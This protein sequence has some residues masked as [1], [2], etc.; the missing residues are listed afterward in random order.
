MQDGLRFVDCDMSMMEP[1]DLF[2]AYMDHK[3]KVVSFC[4]SERIAVPAVA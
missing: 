3:L 1:P 2:K 4:Q